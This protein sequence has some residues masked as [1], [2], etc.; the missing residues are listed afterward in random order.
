MEKGVPINGVF[1][2]INGQFPVTNNE[3]IL[4]YYTLSNAYKNQ[5]KKFL[6]F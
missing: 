4:A 1:V 6:F 2:K 3:R 5:S